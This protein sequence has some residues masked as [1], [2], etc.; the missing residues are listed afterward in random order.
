MISPVA[1]SKWEGLGNDFLLLPGS[2]PPAAPEWARRWCDR[3][4]GIGADGLLFVDDGPR[5]VLFN[6]DGS[7]GSMCG[8]ALR[9]IGAWWHQQGRL[10]VGETLVV[11]TDCGPRSLLLAG[12]DQVEV[13]MELP[14]PVEGCEAVLPLPEIGLPGHFVSM[15]NPHLVVL[16]PEGLPSEEDFLRWGA[17]WQTA[18][19]VPEGGINIEFVA[20]QRERLQVKVWERGVG[21]TRACGSGACAALVTA[22][23]V[24]WVAGPTWVDLPGGA[25]LV[26]WDGHGSVYMSGPARKVFEGSFCPVEREDA[27]CQPVAKN[28]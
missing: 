17:A 18:P 12:P 24:G 9:C 10:G 16:C 6:A 25:L 3:R 5:M 28:F 22:V 19:F 2:P 21:P 8:N 1:F 13:N 26:A 11:E 23:K 27:A 4:L 7:R 14:G 20:R 15:G